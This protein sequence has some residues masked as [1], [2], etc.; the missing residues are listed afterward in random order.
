MRER[1]VTPTFIIPRQARLTLKMRHLF[2]CKVTVCMRCMH[3]ISLAALPKYHSMTA[4][5]LQARHVPVYGRC[6]QGALHQCS[7]RSYQSLPFSMQSDSRSIGT[8]RLGPMPAF[9][10]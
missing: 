4:R 5:V 9:Y 1:S 7:A 2:V 3:S 10:A 6:P 8:V